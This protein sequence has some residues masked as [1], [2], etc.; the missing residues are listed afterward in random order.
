[1]I[2]LVTGVVLS[3]ASLDIAFHD[4]LEIFSIN[5]FNY[6]N[7]IEDLVSNLSPLILNTKINKKYIQAF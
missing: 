6:M 2:F 1:V 5:S 4:S 3:N 7:K